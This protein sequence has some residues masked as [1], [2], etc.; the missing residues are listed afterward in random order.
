MKED[1]LKQYDK[2]LKTEYCQ[3][4]DDIRKKMMVLSYYKYG[5]LKPS[6]TQKL[7][8]PIEGLKKRLKKYEETGNTEYLADVANFAMIEFMYPQK[9]GAYYKPTDSNESPGLV[10][11]SIKEIEDYNKM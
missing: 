4:F 5:A 2:L 3:K 1:A 9:E 10:G 11:M 7:T 6:I 8:N